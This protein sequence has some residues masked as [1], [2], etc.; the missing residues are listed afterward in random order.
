MNE[1][2]IMERGINRRRQL[3]L[4]HEKTANMDRQTPRRRLN[5]HTPPNQGSRH[6]GRRDADY[7][8]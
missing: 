8:D 6:I 4:R 2:I 1:M 7:D 5:I 3:N